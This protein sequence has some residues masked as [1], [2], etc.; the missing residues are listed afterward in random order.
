MTTPVSVIGNGGIGRP[1]IAYLRSCSDYG[2]GAVLTRSG[3]MADTDAFFET[4]ADIVI[5]SAGPE[6]LRR[7]GPQ[8]LEQSEVWTV[9]ASALADPDF[10]GRMLEASATNG[11]RLRLFSD[12]FAVADHSVPGYKATVHFHAARPGLASEPGVVF[13][14]PL[15]DAARIYP[16]EVNSVV[17]AALCGPGIDRATIELISSGGEH[18]I[19]ADIDTGYSRVSSRVEFTPATADA[20]HPTAAAII[21]ALERRRRCVVYG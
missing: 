9:S 13:E 4:A 2:L 12:W 3:R 21:A 11:H 20:I 10:H 16:N 1:I 18:F 14:G 5:D 7:F 8:I 6:A 17:A 15:R 19:S